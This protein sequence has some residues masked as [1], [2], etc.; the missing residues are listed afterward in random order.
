MNKMEE[1]L[2]KLNQLSDENN[3][4]L[5]IMD[6][7]IEVYYLD[8]EEKTNIL[9][10]P[11]IK[12][13]LGDE[14]LK[15]CKNDYYRY[16]EQVLNYLS[17]S[18]LLSLYDVETLKMYFSNDNKYH[19]YKLFATC[20]NKDANETIKYVLQNDEMFK[21][22]FRISDYFYSTFYNLDYDLFKQV[23]FK[24]EELNVPYVSDFLGS[25]NEENQEQILKEDISDNTTLLMLS[26]FRKEIID[27][28]LLNNP[29]AI[30]LFEKMNIKRFVLDGNKFNIN[31]IRQPDFFEML[32]GESFVELRTIIN[33]FEKN[34]D[35]DIIEKRL[36]NYYDEL[37]NYYDSNTEMFKLYA[38]LLNNPEYYY[39]NHI[40]NT[41]VFSSDV[42]SYFVFHIDY[43]EY[44]NR[45]VT[46][47]EEVG[48]TFKKFTSL[49][50]SEIITDAL[51]QDNLYNVRLN[52]K[53]MLRYN[54]KLENSSIEKEW[55]EF[56]QLI[57]NFDNKRKN[58][59]VTQI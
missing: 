51:F 40:E 55:L 19:E 14:I 20:M 16:F 25:I 2:N 47:K 4:S 6:I 24:L 13:I 23:I 38:E 10:N 53:E 32:K 21:E 11:E 36:N 28:F 46:P 45:I 34:N 30:Y 59:I 35:I 44:G 3:T 43:D 12:K 31:I 54:S 29:K 49:K 22:F 58:N 7:L 56:Y 26:C 15:Y 27:D 52:L 18:E 8:S 5:T 50:L 37:I 9:N 1:I 17:I 41:F 48:E 42:H 57:L 33:A 39:T